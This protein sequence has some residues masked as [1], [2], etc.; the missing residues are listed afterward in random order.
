ML[1]FRPKWHDPSQD[2]LSCANELLQFHLQSALDD[3]LTIR[4]TKLHSKTGIYGFWP[5]TF[6]F[7][8]V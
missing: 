4:Q 8:S 3:L 6:C 5:L 7:L 2:E 1:N